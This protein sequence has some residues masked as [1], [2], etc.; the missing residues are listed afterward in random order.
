ME[1]GDWDMT[2]NAAVDEDLFGRPFDVEGAYDGMMFPVSPLSKQGAKC[3]RQAQRSSRHEHEKKKNR[4]RT[5]DIF[6]EQ[7][8]NHV[9]V[10]PSISLLT[11]DEDDTELMKRPASAKK[12]R[13]SFKPSIFAARPTPTFMRLPQL[14]SRLILPTKLKTPVKTLL[15]RPHFDNASNIPSKRQNLSSGIPVLKGSSVLKSP[16][17]S[18]IPVRAAAL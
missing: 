8:E 17:K 5:L 4:R 13:L 1:D 7:F 16:S 11:T 6:Q 9:E 2:C 15:K 18:R 12:P 10:Q 3:L 14:P